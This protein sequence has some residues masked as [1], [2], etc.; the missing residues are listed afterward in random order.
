MTDPFRLDAAAGQLLRAGKPAEALALLRSR[1]APT[2]AFGLS[3]ALELEALI[4]LGR[5]REARA[6]LDAALTVKEPT[7]DALD[8]LAFFARQL[9]LH[10]VSNR[11]YQRTVELAPLDPRYWF[12]L[13]TSERSLGR[14]EAAADA[15]NR[16]LA[17][18]P[19]HRAALLLRSEVSRATASANHVDDLKARLERRL[20]PGDE[21]VFAYALGKELHEL[22]RYDEAFGAFA[23]GAAARRRALQYDVRQDEL[24]LQRIAAAFSHAPPQPPPLPPG[25]HIFI[26]GLPRSGTTLTER[27]LGGLPNVRSNNETDN[28]STALM[29]WTPQ[30]PDDVFERAARADFVRMGQ[31]YEAL[32]DLDDFKGKIIEKLPFNFLYVGAILRALPDASVVW[33]RRHPIDSCFA[34]FRTLFGAAYPFSYDFEELARY[35]AAYERLMAHWVNLHPHRILPVEYEQ[36]VAA[37]EAI[38][39]QLAKHCGLPWDASALEISRNRSASLTASAAQVRGGIYQSSSG[40]WRSYGAHLQ[41]LADLLARQGV[42]L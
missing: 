27:I 26:V 2:Q 23:R 31:D 41:P 39:P 35:F 28:V 3:S 6:A 34:M 19:D 33:L 38:A 5:R 7:P 8:A 11:L 29:R 25:R 15:C 20:P 32:A 14:L 12:N 16:A 36:L 9:E 1:P 21:I 17:L 37:P 18:D 30:G 10:D 13:A 24:K 4:A 42:T 40:I 22:G